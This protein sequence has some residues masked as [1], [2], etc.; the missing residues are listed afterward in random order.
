MIREGENFGNYSWIV[1]N[2]YK[3]CFEPNS[4]ADTSCCEPADEG[5][6]YVDSWF[7]WVI[8][9]L[10]PVYDLFI[11]VIFTP[12]LVI[13]TTV[14]FSPRVT[15]TLARY[16]SVDWSSTKVNKKFFPLTTCC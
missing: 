8:R 10:G 13:S 1:D 4:D 5:L 6:P 16:L 9:S 2:T 15:Y 14:A 11:L 7:D 3:N 12:F